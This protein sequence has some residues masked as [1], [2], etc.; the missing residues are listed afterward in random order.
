MLP[1]EVSC[2]DNTCSVNPVTI[3]GSDVAVVS[4]SQNEFENVVEIQ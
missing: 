1:K 2:D 3:N 4:E